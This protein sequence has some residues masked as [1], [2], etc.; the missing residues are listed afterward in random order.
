MTTTEAESKKGKEEFTRI[1]EEEHNRAQQIITIENERIMKLQ[2]SND[3]IQICPICLDE[4]PPMLQPHQKEKCLQMLCCNVSH[5]HN[6]APKSL[7][8]M[9]EQA[10]IDPKKATCYNCREPCRN[11]S[12]WKND[13]QPNDHRH[14]TMTAVAM[15]YVDG[16]DGFQQGV[17]KNIKKGM[18]LFKRAATLG[19]A[20]AQDELARRYQWGDSGPAKDIEMARHYAEKGAVQ[21][22]PHSQA[23]VATKLWESTDVNSNDEEEAFHLMTLSAFQGC[24]HGRLGLGKIYETRHQRMT[25]GDAD[26]RKA[27]ML[28]VYWYGKAAE[29]E[30]KN[31]R[32]CYSLTWMALHLDIAMRECW[33]R[34]DESAWDPLTGYSHVPFYIWALEKGGVYTTELKL[35]NCWKNV[36]ANCGQFRKVKNQLKACARCKAFYYCS[37]KCQVEHWKAG[38]KVDCKGH[39]I[40]EFFPEMRETQT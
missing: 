13:I 19:N 1:A 11:A 35:S 5:C 24:C 40:E 39:W 2:R 36:C 7:D 12:D 27:I 32:G 34:R 15:Y 37:K 30:L 14:W 26:W 29:V 31:E 4:I 28:S 6:C 20:L 10:R 38:H 33:H 23:I 16:V 22:G 3:T 21:G 18:K 17:K 25:P 8:N 9:S